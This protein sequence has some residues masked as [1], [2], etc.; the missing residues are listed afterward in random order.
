MADGVGNKAG[1]MVSGIVAARFVD[2]KTNQCLR[3]DMPGRFFK[4]F[5]AGR[6]YKAFIFF[7]VPGGLVEDDLT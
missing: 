3:P 5:T 2:V 1:A 6:L 4:G 7:N